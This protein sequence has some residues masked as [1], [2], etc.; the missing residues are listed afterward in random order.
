FGPSTADVR[1]VRD[2]AEAISAHLGGGGV[3]IESANRAHHEARL[4][5]LNCDKAHQLLGWYPRWTADKTIDA[6]ATWYKTVLQG[7]V[8]E[9]VTRSQVLDYFP[10]LQ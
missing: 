10:E 1:T 8:A 7:A 4:L 6:T 2:V 3:E 5:Q 9:M